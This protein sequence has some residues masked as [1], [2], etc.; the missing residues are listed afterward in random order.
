MKQIFFF[1]FL[2]FLSAVYAQDKKD[3]VYELCVH[4]RGYSESGFVTLVRCGEYYK[5][6]SGATDVPDIIYDAN[7][8]NVADCGGMPSPTGPRPDVPL[9]NI[10]CSKDN[11]CHDIMFDCSQLKSYEQESC[12]MLNLRRKFIFK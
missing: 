5:G 2:F 4:E 7:G 8:K 9:C 10:S 3:V 1:I 12:N 6:T 11:L